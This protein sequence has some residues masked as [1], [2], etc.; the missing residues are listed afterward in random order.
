MTSNR[1]HYLLFA[2]TRS[3]SDAPHLQIDYLHL[4]SLT[5]VVVVMWIWVVAMVEDIV[6]YG[7]T[8]RCSSGG[9]VCGGGSGGDG[10]RSDGGGGGGGGGGGR[11]GWCGSGGDGGCRGYWSLRRCS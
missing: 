11:G 8:R 9:V 3:T 10:G 6:R 2:S 5:G 1:G 7:G 4:S